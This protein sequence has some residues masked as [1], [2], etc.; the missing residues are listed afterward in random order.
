V[1][2]RRPL[3]STSEEEELHS[4]E[5]RRA[6]WEGKKRPNNA[7]CVSE[8][9]VEEELASRPRC[10]G[11]LS[12]THSDPLLLRLWL[13]RRLLSYRSRPSLHRD[14]DADADVDADEKE[15]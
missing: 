7:R 6:E 12:S 14:R 3:G 4:T 5:Q 11:C 1:M 13:R 2:K 15:P 10:A 9:S 8:W